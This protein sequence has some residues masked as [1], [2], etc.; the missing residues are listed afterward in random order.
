MKY[1]PD[2]HHRHSIRL[3]NFDYSSEGAYFITICMENRQ[4]I[5]ASIRRGDP[6]GR[7][8]IELTELGEL[9]VNVF[10]DI[11]IKYNVFIS[12]YV[13]M[14]NH[15]HFILVI[16]NEDISIM[17]DK[18]ELIISNE[19]KRATARVAPTVGSI[20]GGYKSLIANSWLKKCKKN[21]IFMGK[22][23]Q[24]NYYEHIIRDERDYNIKWDY[25]NNNPLNWNNDEYYK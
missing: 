20:I 25:I 9:C 23:W 6:C 13:I 16:S 11:E 1:N 12:K 18:N 2:I 4:C 17:S 14:P 7:P 8:E 21:N 10:N 5:L 15:I 22:L 24:R 19:D 3:K